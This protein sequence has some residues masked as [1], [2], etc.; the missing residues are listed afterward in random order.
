M[1]ADTMA[2]SRSNCILI[3]IN[4]TKRPAKRYT[5]MTGA[6][7]EAGIEL[8]IVELSDHG[9]LFI[10]VIRVIQVPC[11]ADV[12]EPQRSFRPEDNNHE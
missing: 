5:Y 7:A 9:P 2:G 3:S 12:N 6:L 8:A 4:P 10:R 11:V 1:P